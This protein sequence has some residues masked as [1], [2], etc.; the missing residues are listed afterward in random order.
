MVGS[1]E[2]L[3]R[4]V[5]YTGYKVSG[6]QV[7]DRVWTLVSEKVPCDQENDPYK[8]LLLDP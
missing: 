1:T 3:E 8:V 7:K 5:D 6:Q 4:T 2:S